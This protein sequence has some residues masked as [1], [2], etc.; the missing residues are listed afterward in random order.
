MA[1]TALKPATAEEAEE[2]RASLEVERAAERRRE[3]ELRVAER[4]ELRAAISG[5]SSDSFFVGFSENISEGGVFVSTFCPPAVGEG[6]DLSLALDGGPA[7]L[8]RGE[9]RWHR[10]NER[11]EPSGCGVRF[12]GLHPEQE[13]ILKD[14]LSRA[15]REPLFYEA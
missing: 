10:N 6:V 5:S 13:E 12:V 2:M 8:V 14:A 7:L 15:G 11:G 4:V 1:N 9:V 3:E